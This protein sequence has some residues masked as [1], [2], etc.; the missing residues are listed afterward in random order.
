MKTLTY[1]ITLLV[2]QLLF[3]ATIHAQE[4]KP[5]RIIFQ[6]VTAD[7]MAHKAQM[8]QLGN[9]TSVSPGIQIEIVCHGP[10]LEMLQS[11]KTTV[12]Q[13]L[14]LF[15]EKGVKFHACEFSL[16]ERKVEKSSLLPGITYVKAGILYIVEKQEEGWSYIKAGF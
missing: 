16:K 14:Q 9:L 3:F 7:S 10:G 5:H 13:N 1:S 8:K 2:F 11:E 6:M 15:I 4:S 12:A